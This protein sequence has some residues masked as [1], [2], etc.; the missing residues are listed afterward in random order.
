MS[1]DLARLRAATPGV[2]NRIH[3]N[4]AGAALMPQPVLEAQLRHL[5]REAE[6]GGY[7]AADEAKGAIAAVYASVAR[8]IGATPD[9][10]ALVENATVAWQMAFYA[11]ARDFRPGDRILTARAE[12]GANY[13]AFL[14]AARRTGAVI[15]VISDDAT[16]ATDPAALAAMLDDR[17]RLIALTW[18]P[19]NGGLVNPAAA[20]GRIARQHGIPYLLDACQAVGQLPVDVA[21]LGCDF[22]T[23]TGRKFLRGPRGTGFLY[24]RRER[25]AGLEPPM[26][27]HHGAVWTAPDSYT[28]RPDARRFETWENNYGAQL[29]LGAAIDYALTLGLEEIEARCQALANRLREGLR[30]IPGAVVHDLGTRPAAIVSFTLRDREA[31]EVKARCAAT[32]I[33]LST[34]QPSST[35]LDATARG[36]PP[37]VRASPHCYNAEAEIDR[38]LEVI[39]AIRR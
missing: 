18:I 6:I 33:N 8:L 2:A 15:E 7:E 25:L 36:L 23:A 12:Y 35:L 26:L 13:V 16:G 34:S 10:V 37:L 38:A 5:R 32:G 20:I 31:A 30:A 28:L 4:N 39:A 19:T 9:E 17:V 29:G 1:L 22:L 11:L 27:D 21:E 24:V 3:L 14:Q